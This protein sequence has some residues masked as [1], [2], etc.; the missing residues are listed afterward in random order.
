MP[1]TASG[2][3]H[4]Y[5]AGPCA[6][7]ALDGI[8]LSVGAGELV[9]LAGP[10]GSGKSTLLH[11]LSGVLRPS[12]GRIAIDGPAALAI[13]FPE[14]A[15][16]ADTVAADIAFGPIGKGLPPDEAGRRAVEAA[17]K[18]GLDAGL[19]ARRPR[20]L[21]QGQRRLAALAGVV[22]TRPRYLFADEPTAGLD[23]SSKKRV[24]A[25][26]GGLAR[27]GVA[28]VVASHDLAL[29]LPACRRVLVMG[30]GR[31][32]LD[33]GPEDLVTFDGAA[34]LNLPPSL[35]IARDLREKGVP[36]PWDIGPQAAAAC[37]GRLHGRQV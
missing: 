16:F 20:E 2:V 9:L 33:G 19:L 11:C 3:G 12:S 18:V 31:L 14:R 6:R 27:D 8:D 26:L 25:L 4:T 32:V 34:G 36:V 17:E 30:G 15:L 7:R 37:L 28:V 10:G 5:R 35:A 22:A 23:P 29:F 1:L 13:Q 24:V 21:S